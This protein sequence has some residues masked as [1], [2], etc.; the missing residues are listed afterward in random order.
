MRRRVAVGALLCAALGGCADRPADV[1]ECRELA[2]NE[3]WACKNAV[4]RPPSGACF[5][6]FEASIKECKAVF[7]D[8]GER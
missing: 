4:A 8:E 2:E 3:Y 7:L 6:R 5:A 1:G